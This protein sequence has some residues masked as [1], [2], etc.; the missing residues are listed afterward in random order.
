[1]YLLW[2]FVEKSTKIL[3][4]TA[5]WG[6]RDGMHDCLIRNSKRLDQ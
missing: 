1:M 4:C 2:E 3:L 6:K 5:N